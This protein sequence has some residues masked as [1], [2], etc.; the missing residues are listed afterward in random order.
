SHHFLGVIL[1]YNLSGKH[2]TLKY[3]I[4]KGRKISDIISTLSGVRWGSHPGFL[5][6]RSAIEYG[7]QFFSWNF[8]ASE[9]VKLQRLQCKVIRKVMGYRISTLINVMLC[10]A[11]EFK[12]VKY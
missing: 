10:E 8:S 5:T 12:K 7:C 3:L 9:F 2:Y 1:D 4:D 6:F 11:K